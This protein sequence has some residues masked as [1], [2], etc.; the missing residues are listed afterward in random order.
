LLE[1]PD[2]RKKFADKHGKE[3]K[4]PETWRTISGSSRR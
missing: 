1:D 2:N 4:F 3:L